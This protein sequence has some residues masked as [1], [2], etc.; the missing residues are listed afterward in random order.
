MTPTMTFV[1]KE[2]ILDLLRSGDPY[3]T[4]SEVTETTLTTLYYRVG[5]DEAIGQVVMEGEQ[6]GAVTSLGQRI[7]CGDTSAHPEMEKI[8]RSMSA[9]H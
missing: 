4:E 7:M 3:I 2:A 1:H 6:M 9:A 5:S 8:Q